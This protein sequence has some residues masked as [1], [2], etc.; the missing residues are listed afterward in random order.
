[1]KAPQIIFIIL[2]A[3]SFGHHLAMH[4]KD[5]GKFHVGYTLINVLITVVLLWWGGF[6]S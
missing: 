4:G 2:M 3:M 1:M 6:F 5:R